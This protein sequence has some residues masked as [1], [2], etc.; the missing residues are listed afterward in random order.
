MIHRAILGSLERFIAVILEHTAG[1]LPFWLNP[2]QICVVP[3]RTEQTEY[4][5][6]VASKLYELG[7]EAM[8]DTSDE[9]MQKKLAQA[10]SVG[11]SFVCVVGQKECEQ[12]AVTIQGRSIVTIDKISEA[13]A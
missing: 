5:V 2:K 1:K 9:K 4:A 13:D 12:N 3:A 10:F 7:Y 11:Y 6:N 8:A